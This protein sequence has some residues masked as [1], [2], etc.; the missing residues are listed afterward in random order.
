MM[1]RKFQCPSCQ[2][3]HLEYEDAWNCCEIYTKWF[4]V[5]C[6]ESQDTKGPC[7]VCATAKAVEKFEKEK[8]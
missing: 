5:T 6:G 1:I 8:V 4:C 2:T 3:W 7:E